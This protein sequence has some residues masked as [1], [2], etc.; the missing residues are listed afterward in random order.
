MVFSKTNTSGAAIL[1]HANL[2]IWIGLIAFIWSRAWRFGF[3]RSPDEVSRFAPSLWDVGAVFFTYL[4]VQLFVASALVQVVFMLKGVPAKAVFVDAGAALWVLIAGG[5]LGLLF[6]LPF[7]RRS[8]AQSPQIWH[9]GSQ[10]QGASLR[11]FGFGAMTWLIAFPLVAIL[12]HG[13]E[14]L[15]RWVTEQSPHE[16][17][18]VRIIKNSGATS[19][20]V[21]LVLVS[22]AVLIP[23]IE[24]ILFR[25]FLQSYFRRHL[26]A[27]SAIVCSAICFSLFHF[28]VSQS[29]SNVV[30]VVSLFIL[31]LF[32]GYI[33]ERQRSLWAPIGLHVTFNAV[34]LSYI[35][36]SS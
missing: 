22:V 32:L 31:G 12:N 28:S 2:W 33:Y 8:E 10:Q 36:T 25:G 1:E 13:L 3:F 20:Q 24:E 26:G 11:N 9:W 6:V 35:L 34:S 4:L 5:F 21:I 16:Q 19:L 15:I 23:V 27:Q 30:I 14:S 18:A 7:T 17:V 29:W